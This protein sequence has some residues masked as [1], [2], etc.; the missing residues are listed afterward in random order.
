M[1]TLI[2][3]PFPLK[4]DLPRWVCSGK[5]PPLPLCGISPKGGEKARKYTKGV[6]RAN[7]FYL[8]YSFRYWS[9]KNFMTFF[10]YQNIILN[11]NTTD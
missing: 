6:L 3:T 1:E 8:F 4:R 9:A 5:E 2:K 10:G 11:T 7:R